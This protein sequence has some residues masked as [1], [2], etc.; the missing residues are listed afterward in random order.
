MNELGVVSNT[1]KHLCTCPMRAPQFLHVFILYICIPSYSYQTA[2]TIE[3]VHMF[4]LLFS[5]WKR[6]FILN[7]FSDDKCN[8]MNNE[9]DK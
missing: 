1:L 7:K 8:Q 9:N 5:Y 3:N 2:I 4:F 6:D